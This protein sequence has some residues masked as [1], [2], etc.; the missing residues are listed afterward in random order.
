MNDDISLYYI[1]RYLQICSI[2]RSRGS[3]YNITYEGV[4]VVNPYNIV[5]HEPEIPQNTGNIA[6]TCSVTGASLH[7][8]R[9]LGFEVS[10]AKLKRAGLDYWNTLDIHYYD[11][12]EECVESYPNGHFWFYTSKGT[13]NFSDVSYDLPVFLVFGK[14]TAGLPESLIKSHPDRCVRIPMLSDKRC[15]NLSNAAAVGLYEALRQ[16]DYP[17]LRPSADIMQP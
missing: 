14:E 13:L 15:L 11:S 10:D 9:P 8:I 17:G 3:E 16:H 5:L 4:I 12:L 6:R 7:L 2:E 1:F